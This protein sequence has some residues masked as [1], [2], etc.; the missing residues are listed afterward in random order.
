MAY[1]NT[2]ILLA[3]LGTVCFGAGMISSRL[4][5]R[6]A[7]ARTGAAI[8]VPTATLLFVISAPFTVDA[9]TFNLD[10]ALIFAAVGLFYPAM[11]TLITF[12]SNEL[13][14]PTMTSAISGTAPLFA[15][16]AAALLLGEQVPAQVAVAA[17]G[18]AA[19]VA[20]LSW[21]PGLSLHALHG[22]ALLWPVG[23]ALLRGLAQTGAKAGLLVWA[24]PF[25][26]SLIGYLVSSAAVFGAAHARSGGRRQASAAGKRWFIAT[27]IINGAAM[28]LMYGALAQAPVSTV[29]PI[30]AAYPLVTVLGSALFLREETLRPQMVCG[31][32]I[33]VA[34]VAWLAAHRT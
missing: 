10:A 16:L 27:G 2:P 32:I 1:I 29:A 33:T 17:L 20:L 15:I 7:D 3:I 24:N 26:A 11:V 22:R 25:A 21:Q 31:A 4:G 5:L 14:G 18:V 19:G 13:L 9:A 12:R 28:V 30:I 23:G 6:D 8:S 34:A